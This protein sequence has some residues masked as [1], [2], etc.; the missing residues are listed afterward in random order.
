MPEMKWRIAWALTM[1]VIACAVNSGDDTGKPGAPAKPRLT[2]N[3]AVHIETHRAMLGAEF[4]V[5][6]ILFGSA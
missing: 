1:I 4:T 6:T 2:I 5:D 3:H